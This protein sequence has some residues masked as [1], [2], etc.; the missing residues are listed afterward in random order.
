MDEP[1][2]TVVADRFAVLTGEVVC[3]KCAAKTPVAALAVGEHREGMELGEDGMDLVFERCFEPALLGN[4]T[5]IDPDTLRAVKAVAPWMDLMASATAGEVYLGNSCTHCGVLQGDW[6]LRE[7]EAPFFPMTD[8][9]ADLLV[10]VWQDVQLQAVA[11]YGMSSWLDD[12][13]ERRGEYVSPLRSKRP[14]G[15]KGA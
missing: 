12:L 2:P 11:D 4:I 15:A 6:F 10:V 7:P 5:W 8:E 1:I 14:R 13:L 9:A 3:F